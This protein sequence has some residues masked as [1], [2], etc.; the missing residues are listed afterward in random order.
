MV[1]C[2]PV[3]EVCKVGVGGV[4]AGD[5]TGLRPPEMS[6]MGLIPDPPEGGFQYQTPV[7]TVPPYEEAY[8]CFWGT[9]PEDMAVHWFEWFQDPVHGHHMRMDRV[10]NV[11]GPPDGTVVDCLG[12]EVNYMAEARN[13]FNATEGGVISGRMRLEDD[14]GVVVRGGERWVIQSH[15]LNVTDQEIK[16]QDTV[17]IGWN[18]WSEIDKPISTWTFDEV[19]FELP[20]NQES[21]IKFRCTW[22]QDV[23]VVMWMVHMH[24]RG[25]SFESRVSQEEGNWESWYGLEEWNPEWYHQAKIEIPPEAVFFSEGQILEGT[26]RIMNDTDQARIWPEEMCVIEGLAWPL[27][28]GI[29][30]SAVCEHGFDSE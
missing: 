23:N 19:F 4:G 22:P 27:Y 25:L 5:D 10:G 21:E 9:W 24:D 8:K 26:C 2:G 7:Y 16:V 18:P 11:E 3:A 15:F 28:D 14:M 1:S 20:P 12:G 30:A 29:L 13:L 17:N 6:W